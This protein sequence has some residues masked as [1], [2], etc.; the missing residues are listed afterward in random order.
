MDE[1]GHVTTWWQYVQDLIGSDNFSTAANKAGFDK[2][3]F[4][5]WSRGANADP[6]FAVKLA[7]AYNANPIHALVV[8]GLLSSEEAKL[9]MVD[10]GKSVDARILSD[11]ELIAE[12]KRRLRR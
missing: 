4:T 5:R 11:D 8:S 3:A 12:I 9:R 6:A 7:R 10:I 2:S 1:K